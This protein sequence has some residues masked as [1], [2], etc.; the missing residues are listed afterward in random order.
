MNKILLGVILGAVLG[1]FDGL[2]ALVTSPGV[3][4]KIGGI[5][6]GSTFKG[7]VT[8]VLMGWFARRVQSVPLGIVLGLI[9]GFALAYAVVLTLPPEEKQ[10]YWE[11]ILPGSAVGVIVGFATQKYGRAPVRATTSTRA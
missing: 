2:S 6:A 8:G 11:I 3:A 10:Y 7:I 1:A 4:E 5:V 9:V